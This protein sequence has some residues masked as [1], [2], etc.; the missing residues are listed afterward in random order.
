LAELK[1][2][3]PRFDFKVLDDIPAVTSPLM[4]TCDNTQYYSRS[5]CNV[6]DASG[7]LYSVPVYDMQHQFIGLVSSIVRANVFEAALLNMPFLVLTP[8]TRKK[9]PKPG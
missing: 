1:A 4:R 3:H 8:K 2:S 7:F 5:Q 9:R 6:Y